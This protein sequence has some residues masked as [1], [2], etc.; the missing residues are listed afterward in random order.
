ML[1]DLENAQISYQKAIRELE[2]FK[3]SSNI[4]LTYLNMGY[5]FTKYQD[6]AGAKE[7]FEKGLLNLN[8]E[9]DKDYSI[10]LYA[11]LSIADSKLGDQ[12]KS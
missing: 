3:D 5:I 2:E 8:E 6:W 11:S 10:P 4:I 7:N 1:N 12:K 9:S